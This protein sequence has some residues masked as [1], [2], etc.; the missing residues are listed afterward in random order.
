MRLA[1]RRRGDVCIRAITYRAGGTRDNDGAV[2]FAVS[3]VANTRRNN[4][5]STLP[6]PPRMVRAPT[7]GEAEK[8]GKP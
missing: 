5:K 3:G 7:R 1:F 2:T 6:G 4:R 8:C